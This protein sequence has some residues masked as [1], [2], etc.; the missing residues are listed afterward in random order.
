MP[1]NSVKSWITKFGH[2]YLS[3]YYEW[4][5]G[6]AHQRQIRREFVEFV[7]PTD[8]ESV[9]EFG[10][11]PGNLLEMIAPRC[12]FATGLDESPHM[13]TRAGRRLERARLANVELIHASIESFQADQQF[14]RAVGVGFLYLFPKPLE[15]LWRMRAAVRPAGGVATMSPSGTLTRSSVQRFIRNHSLG[16]RER[17]V[18]RNWLL[19]AHFNNRFT[20][21]EL[22]K[23]YA[24]AGL[25]DIE[26]GHTLDGM[27][28]YAKAR[29]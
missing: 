14:D 16:L 1:A 19:A 22:N 20:D 13:L 23:L 6:V 3:G 21:R 28:V 17:L 10:C 5:I 24:D 11:G 4:R 12:W 18:L 15:I 27:V 7:S 29:V 25:R 2:G 26:L 8:D 9:I